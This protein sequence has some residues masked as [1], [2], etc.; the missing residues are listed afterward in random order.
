MTIH[1]S[2]GLGFDIVLLPELGGNAMTT[3]RDRSL[4]VHRDATHAIDWLLALPPALIASADPVLAEHLARQEAE[5]CYEQL[6]KFYVALTRAKR[7]MYLI[8]DRPPKSP[9]SKNFPLLL[10]D[11]LG[12]EP[13]ELQLGDLAVEQVSAFGP[14]DWFTAFPTG[15]ASEVTVPDALALP[16]I[17]PGAL[18]PRHRRRTPSSAQPRALAAAQLFARSGAAGRDFGN[19]VHALFE[20]IEWL[21]DPF[22]EAGLRKRWE[23]LH[24]PEAAIAEV[25]ACLR[26]PSLRDLFAPSEAHCWRERRF[27]IVLDGD[28]LSGAFDRVL[29]LSDSARIIDFKTDRIPKPEAYAAQLAI[30]RRALAKL[31]GF[32]ESVITCELVFTATAEAFPSP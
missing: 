7:G 13:V 16:R 25:L 29:L 14:R 27:E 22:D 21:A 9:T 32:P 15:V 5:A 31:T 28:W 26:A 8:L 12:G 19:A 10:D 30:Y 6:C 17:D 23:S 4:A 20:S 11:T 1:K 18:S 3:V 24:A 2:K